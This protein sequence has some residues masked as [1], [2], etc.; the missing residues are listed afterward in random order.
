[1]ELTP[2]ATTTV[3]D[4][5]DAKAH[6]TATTS[7]AAYVLTDLTALHDEELHHLVLD[8]ESRTLWWA[9]DLAPIDGEGWTVDQWSPDA[10]AEMLSD[11]IDLIQD[12]MDDPQQYA[13]GM[14]DLQTDQD[15]LDEYAEIL[16]MRL[17]AEPAAAAASIRHR[18]K[19][20]ARQDALWQRTYA[21]LVR[22]L[23]GTEHGGKTQASKAI[24]V[25]DVQIG[26]IIR[27]DQQ[28]RE[29]ME[30]TVRNLRHADA[31]E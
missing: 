21:A 6:I 2:L 11:Q 19:L 15:A 24:G 14:A 16:R 20:I 4:W 17:P 25:T 29:A 5:P 26:R 23:A 31:P 18:R 3:E 27:E 8:P 1:M 30:Q 12:R 13:K 7:P 22:D 9:Y 10:A 28:R